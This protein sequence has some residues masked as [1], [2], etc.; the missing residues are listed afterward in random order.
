MSVRFAADKLRDA[1]Y[2][3][4]I[5]DA[6]VPQRWHDAASHLETVPIDALPEHARAPFQDL[7]AHPPQTRDDYVEAVDALFVVRD[8]TD[9]EDL[10]SDADDDAD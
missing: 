10:L 9:E 7:L 4:A 6:A 2:A 3:L 5:S 1:V 8:M